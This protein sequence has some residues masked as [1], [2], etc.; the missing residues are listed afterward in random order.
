[1]TPE[2]FLKQLEIELKISKKSPHTIRKYKSINNDLLKASKKLPTEINQ[3]DVKLFLA[4]RFSDKSSSAMTQALASIKYAYEK[5]FEKDPTYKIERP[6]K[7]KKIPSVLTK[8]EVQK[9]INVAKTKKSKLIISLIY[10]TGMRVSEL[11]NLKKQDI[12][13]DEGVGHIKQAKGRKDRSFNI[14]NNIFQELKEFCTHSKEYVFEGRKGRLTTRN[15]QK[16]VENARKR[17]GIQK[18]VHV[19]TLR[20]SFATHL[21]DEGVD[22]RTI[23]NILGHENLD[24]TSIYTHISTKKL[25]EVKSPLDKL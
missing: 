15:I 8:E 3:Q 16:I 14:P 17:A 10:G 11:V 4:E 5:I 22:L 21:L 25:R 1:M 24:T 19:H 6:K 7:D 23:Q 13:F 9:L 18:E 12:Y 20:H 2:L